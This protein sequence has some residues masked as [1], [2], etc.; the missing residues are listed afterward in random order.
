MLS[1]AGDLLE[2][3][4]LDLHPDQQDS[5]Q[6]PHEEARNPAD[7]RPEGQRDQGQQQRED[8]AS[9]HGDAEFVN[10]KIARSI[11]QT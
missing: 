8:R 2:A 1:L 7:H 10:S 3:C 11:E 5:D 6:R 9:N 4:R